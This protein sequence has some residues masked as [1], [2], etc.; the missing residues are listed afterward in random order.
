MTP[1]ERDLIAQLFARLPQPTEPRDPEADALIGQTLRQRPDAPYFLVQTVLIEEMALAQA[2]RRIADL[3]RQLASAQAAS[4][5]PQ[6][7]TSFLGRAL[8]SGAAPEARAGASGPWGVAP[9]A[10]PAS[11]SGSVWS[12]TG[13]APASAPPSA[14]TAAAYPTPWGAGGGGFLRQAAATAAGIAG[15]ALLFQG[16]E[17]LF[18]PHYGNL[19]GGMPMQPGISETV[20]NNYNGD[21]AGSGADPQQPADPQLADDQQSDP[22]GGDQDFADDQGAGGDLD[23]SG[24]FDV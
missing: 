20:I 24:N 22:T 18:G 5:P 21:Q 17:S 10:P 3:E 16:I 9:A 23:S 1:Q 12:Q 2:Q 8:S 7:P 6:Q 19:L 15:G 13:G 4:A 14:A 11:P